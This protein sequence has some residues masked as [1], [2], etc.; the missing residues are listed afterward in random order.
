MAFANGI[1]CIG[2]GNETLLSSSDALG[3]SI[4]RPEFFPGDIAA[5]AFTGAEFVGV[6]RGG[7]YPLGAGCDEGSWQVETRAELNDVAWGDGKLV[8]VGEDGFVSSS[9][10]GRDWTL[11]TSGSEAWLSAIVWTGDEFIAAGSEGTVLRSAD[12]TVF[13]AE[14]SGTT[15]TFN[16][17]VV[18]DFGIVAVGYSSALRSGDAWIAAT[19][20][21]VMEAAAWSPELGLVVAV[22]W[23]GAIATSSD[24]LTW[25][26]Q[27]HPSQT[28]L[29]DVT[30]TGDRFVAVGE[31][32]TVLVSSDGM[33][34]QTSFSGRRLLNV[35]W[36][37][38]RFVAVGVGGVVAQSQTG[39][40]WDYSFTGDFNDAGFDAAASDSTFVLGAQPYLITTPDL[41]NFANKTWLG[42]TST[43]GGVVRTGTQ[44][45]AACSDAMYRSSDGSEWETAV[46]VNAT[47]TD[48]AYDGQMLVAVGIGGLIRT[49]VDAVDWTTVTSGTTENLASIAWSGERF[50]AVGASGTILWSEDGQTW[51]IAESPVTEGLDGVAYNGQ[52][53]LAV[54]VNNTVL[55][56]THGISWGASEISDTLFPSPNGVAAANGVDVV[57]GSRGEIWIRR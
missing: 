40:H 56:S 54:G 15:E 27:E 14:D 2:S 50:V 42:A 10:D 6:G 1:V 9:V 25:V 44:F 41:S 37:R 52:E 16:D 47:Y 21:S 12:G 30:W 48:V 55:A 45:V 31:G 28:E 39:E 26:E 7:Y 46:D 43:C 4:A 38:D 11:G 49:S 35:A 57:A 8:A 36:A 34:F 17:L 13:E 29:R 32:G 19:Q 22:G 51:S 20:A 18:T 24:G 33:S 3:F 23:N 5:I 53:F